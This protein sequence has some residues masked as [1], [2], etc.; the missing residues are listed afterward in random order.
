MRTVCASD[1]IYAAITLCS[2]RKS[3][4]G[5]IQHV[6]TL[7]S[8]HPFLPLA[9]FSKANFRIKSGHAMANTCMCLSLYTVPFSVC[10]R[11]PI[12]F[13]EH[14]LDEMSEGYGQ[15]LESTHIVQAA[16]FLLIQFWEIALPQKKKKKRKNF[17]RHYF[18]TYYPRL[19]L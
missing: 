6:L 13:S 2:S 4:N 12:S 18:V 14:T 11:C 8:C 17:L 5:K 7:P 3:F 9:A 16:R 19:Y 15:R 1:Q 10:V